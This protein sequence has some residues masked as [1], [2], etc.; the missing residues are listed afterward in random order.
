MIANCFLVPFQK[1]ALRCRPVCEEES[2]PGAG[3]C[4]GEMVQEGR[5]RLG[6]IS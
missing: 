5:L 3:A 2:I 1:K 6:Q 4:Q